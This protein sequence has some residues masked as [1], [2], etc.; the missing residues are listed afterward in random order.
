MS[1]ATLKKSIGEA[2]AFFGDS[3]GED[4]LLAVLTA[5]ASAGETIG[6][7]QATPTASVKGALLCDVK[8]KLSN[9][10]VKVGTCGTA[11]QT[12]FDVNVNGVQVAQLSVDNAETDGISKGLAIDLD[13]DPGDL[14]ELEVTAVATGVADASATVRIRPVTL[15]T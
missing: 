4:N 8:S 7:S 14:V 11:G 2:G 6:Y 12:D 9:I 5:L 15:E 1:R 3:H 10:Y 13:L